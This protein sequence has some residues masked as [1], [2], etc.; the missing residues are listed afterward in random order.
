MSFS[1]MIQHFVLSWPIFFFYMLKEM[2]EHKRSMLHHRELEN[3]K[4]RYESNLPSF[5]PVPFCMSLFGRT[6]DLFPIQAELYNLSLRF[7]LVACLVIQLARN[8]FSWCQKPRRQTMMSKK[9]HL[10]CFDCN[11][12]KLL[13]SWQFHVYGGFFWSTRFLPFTE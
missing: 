12:I 13:H 5:L 3:L 9:A 4:G 7:T 2:E 8:V 6:P 11:E 1:G 10:H